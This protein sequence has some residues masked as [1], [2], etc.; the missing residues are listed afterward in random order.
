MSARRTKAP[1][2]TAILLSVCFAH[3]LCAATSS[4][5]PAHEATTR[6]AVAEQANDRPSVKPPDAQPTRWSA[7][8][9]VG[10]EPETS[11]IFGAFIQRYFD[12]P[13]KQPPAHAPRT[14]A[15]N[16]TTNDPPPRRSVL[17]LA[18]LLT[19]KNQYLVEFEPTLYLDGGRWRLSVGL[20]VSHFPDAY[21]AIGPNS[22]D[23]SRES[24]TSRSLS[25]NTTLER[26]IFRSLYLGW[27]LDADTAELGDFETDGALSSGNVLGTSGGQLLGMG[28]VVAWDDSDRDFAPRRGGRY[29]FSLLTFPRW[30]GTDYGF[31]ALQFD[32]RRYV[33]I[34]RD[35]VLALQ[36][37]SRH[38]GGSVPFYR[39]SELGGN[40][41]MRGFLQNRYIDRHTL[42]AQGEYRLP[43]PWR[44]G[45]T[46]FVA[47]GDVA[48]R[49]HD[50][51]PSRV[52]FAAGG[53]LRYA[54]NPADGVNLRFDFGHTS[55][56]DTNVYFTVGEAF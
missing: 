20:F 48:P 7:L 46:L 56:A 9:V 54:I 34:V 47:A 44:F 33:P 16:S 4:A 8:P 10:Y 37:F 32:L 40:G 5:D 21:W 6:D 53:G 3:S 11:W 36:L 1:C 38:V 51:A 13:R 24:F 39:L 49:L 18:A 45:A 2:A 23:D 31:A 35:H 55:D 19:L 25:F 22:P 14:N 30:F 50:F 27:S 43:L 52:K 15:S 29:E 17:S 12:S 28:P 41:R 42:S 26:R